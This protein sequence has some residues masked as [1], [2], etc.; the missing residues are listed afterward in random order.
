M[1]TSS[2]EGVSQLVKQLQALGALEDGKVLKAAVTDAIQPALERAHSIVPVGTEAHRLAKRYGY[3]LESP[4]FARDHIKTVTTI[5]RSKTVASAILGVSKAAFYIV[6][7]VQRG[8]RYQ[9]PQP[10]LDRALEETRA[11]CESR[12]RDYLAAAVARI[13]QTK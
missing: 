9:R 8:T 13:A 10:W 11:Q 5:N 6:Q 4:G 2:L 12:L 3:S 1:I 7:F